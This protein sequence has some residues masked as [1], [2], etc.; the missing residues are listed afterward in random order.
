[1]SAIEFGRSNAIPPVTSTVP[2]K[3]D[4]LIVWCLGLAV[5]GSA[6]LLDPFAHAG[7]DAPKRFVAMLA[8]VLGGAALVKQAQF[9]QWRSWSRAAQLIVVFVLLAALGC[10]VSAWTS[11]AQASA[12]ASLRTICVFALFLPLGA[13]RALDG[14]AGSRLLG[15]AALAVTVNAVL[16]LLQATGTQLPIP[17]VKLGGRY[18]TGALLGNEGYVALACALTGVGAL[19]FMLNAKHRRHRLLALVVCLLCVATI[20]INRQL[21]SAV[22]FAAGALT[23]LA[24]R[25]R[26]RWIVA[27][28]AGAVLC[29]ACAALVPSIRNVTWSALPI[30]GV[31]DYQRITTYR[32]GAWAAAVEMVRARPLTGFGPGS[33]AAEA[34]RHRLRAEIRVKARLLP[35]PTA[36]AFVYAHQE[37]LQLAAEMGVPTLLALLLALGTMLI[38]LLRLA[39]S[40]GPTEVLAVVGVIACG[41]VAALAWFPLQVPFTAVLLLLACGRGWRLLADQREVLP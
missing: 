21:T 18:A 23:I 9:P 31:A 20:A 27:L 37:Y 1:M 41:A 28:G 10:W 7:F 38:A 12:W 3:S 16:S 14:P 22:A 19:A 39:S 40:P 34:Q 36:N 5:L 6:W 33:Y 11:A 26:T 30:S 15:I 8:A 32:L 17:M 24:V 35:P 2:D 29:A 25:W 13:S 4:R